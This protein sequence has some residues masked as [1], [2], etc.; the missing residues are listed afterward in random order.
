[1]TRWSPSVAARAMCARPR[2]VNVRCT[3]STGGHGHG[4]H[5]GGPTPQA[6]RGHGGGGRRVVHRGGGGDLRHPRSPRHG[7]TWINTLRSDRAPAGSRARA[8]LPD[9][10]RPPT[11][12]GRAGQS[13]RRGT[14]QLPPITSLPFAGVL[15]AET[16]AAVG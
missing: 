9:G 6:I 2:P 16:G 12:S 8:R 10:H 5:R 13:A 3:T 14:F 4:G 11:A 7:S 1:A 15:D